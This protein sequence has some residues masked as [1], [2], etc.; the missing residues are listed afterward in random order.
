MPIFNGA[1]RKEN[2]IVHVKEGRCFSD[3]TYT[4]HYVNAQENGDFD[5][6]KVNVDVKNQTGWLCSE[7]FL[8]GTRDKYTVE[9]FDSEGSYEIL[10]N[11]LTDD[12][13][14]DIPFNGVDVYLECD[15]PIDGVESFLGFLAMFTQDDFPKLITPQFVEEESI[16]FLNETMH[17]VPEVRQIDRVEIDEKLI[18]SGDFFAETGMDGLAALIEYGTGGRIGH[19]TMALWFGEEL[20][21]VESNGSGIHR[22]PYKQRVQET[23]DSYMWIPLSDEN[24]AK[25]NETAAIEFFNKTNGTAYGFHNFM[26]GWIDTPENNNPP[27]IA[28]K[29]VPI[30]WKIVGDVV[31][32]ITDIFY[33]QALNHHLGTKGLTIPQLA[34]QAAKK[35][36]TLEDL[37]AVVEEDFWDYEGDKP[38]DG[39]SYVCSAYVTAMYKA[40]GIF[41][42]MPINAVE[43]TPKDLYQMKVFKENWERP[44]QC[45]K[46]DPDA[47]FCQLSGK[48]RVSLPGF[49]TIEPYAHMNEKCP[50]MAPN[51]VRP[52]GC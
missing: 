40:A 26:F 51:Y 36:M 33:A 29:L 24:A 30:V 45:V 48:W 14:V 19:S 39:W 28:N 2:D 22:T 20:Y 52:D 16:R 38:K 43:H 32:S 1:L 7:Y 41:G 47:T 34:S 11:N 18:K 5:S 25:F 12:D 10:I 50:S 9:E 27:L 46:A 17:W 31:P 49:N 21:I 42:D 3:I 8:I 6:V 13:K 37:Q 44:E 35:G 23:G 4:L 15:D